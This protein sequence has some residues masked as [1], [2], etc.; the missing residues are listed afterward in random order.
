MDEDDDVGVVLVVFVEF[1]FA[2]CWLHLIVFFA[3]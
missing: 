1:L 3:E 2:K